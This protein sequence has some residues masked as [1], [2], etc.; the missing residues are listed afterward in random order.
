MIR[1]SHPRLSDHESIKGFE[2]YRMVWRPK[3]TTLLSW[4]DRF[5][6]HTSFIKKAVPKE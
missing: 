3:I 6:A 1:K 4:E 5:I 2:V